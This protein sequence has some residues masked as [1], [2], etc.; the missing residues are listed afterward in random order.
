MP[1]ANRVVPLGLSLAAALL[2]GWWLSVSLTTD[3]T[4]RGSR[5]VVDQ[6][7]ASLLNRLDQEGDLPQQDRQRLLMRLLE[8]GRLQEAQLVLGPL[9]QEQP[10]SISL[11]LLMA[12]LRRLNNEPDQARR[13]LDLLLRLH[14]NHPRVLELRVLVEQQQKRGP[15]ALKDIKTRFEAGPKGQRL[16]LGL[17]LG[18]LQ[19]QSGQTKQSAGLFRQLAEESPNDARPLLALAM[20]RQDEGNAKEVQ[21]LLESARKRRGETGQSD[22]LIDDLAARWGLSAIRVRVAGPETQQ[23]VPAETP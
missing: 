15:Q 9:L 10:R 20:Q 12:D 21:A 19:R 23:Q 16:E 1:F 4:A 2:I 5:A 18:D 13:D 11:A 3:T 17:L 7:V 22:Q 8:L 14:P 6:Q